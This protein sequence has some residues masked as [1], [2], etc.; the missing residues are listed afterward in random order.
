MLYNTINNT[1]TKK[2]NNFGFINFKSFFRQDGLY[3]REVTEWELQDKYLEREDLLTSIK[4]ALI[5]KEQRDEKNRS[6][7]RQRE[8]NSKRERERER[9]RERR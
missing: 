4:V 1:V 9:E 2:Y 7:D 5:Q 3:K 8:I 6:I